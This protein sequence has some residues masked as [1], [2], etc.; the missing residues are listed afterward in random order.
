MMIEYVFK[1]NTTRKAHMPNRIRISDRL[2][3]DPT[4]PTREELERLAQEGFRSVVNLRTPGEPN[5]PLSPDAEGEA[6]REVGLDYAHIPVA[7]T[8]PRPEQVD[9]FRQKLSD[10][11]GP[12]LIHCASGKRA[13][14]FGVLGLAMEEGLSG[15]EGLSRARALGF[16]WGGPEIEAFVRQYLDQNM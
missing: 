8:G 15:E 9:E 5:Q 13:S 1:A 2:S 6:A 10:L 14:V 7:P 16:D 12:V 3:V 4:P 11:P